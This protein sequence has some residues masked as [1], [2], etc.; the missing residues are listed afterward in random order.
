[1]NQKHKEFFQKLRQLCEKWDAEIHLE[2]ITIEDIPYS[3]FQIFTKDRNTMML[4]NKKLEYEQTFNFMEQED[5][6]KKSNS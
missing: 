4:L 5:D 2:W 3:T 6:D 1:M